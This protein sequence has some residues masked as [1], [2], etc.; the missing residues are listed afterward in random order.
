MAITSTSYTKSIIDKCLAR[1][2]AE[3]VVKPDTFIEYGPFIE[4]L[5]QIIVEKR[6]VK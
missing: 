6:L 1:G 4:N 5:Y 3:Y 2:A